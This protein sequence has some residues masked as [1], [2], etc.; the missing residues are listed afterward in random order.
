[1]SLAAL[2][3]IGVGGAALGRLAVP[4]AGLRGHYF[5]NLTRSGAPI[6]V[7]IDR[8]L[9]T[10]TLDNGVAGVWPAYSVE[11]SGFLIVDDAGAYDF[12]TTSDDGS[13]LEVADR[14]VVANGG[15]HG[16]KEVRGSIELARGVHPI[17]VRYE[18]AGGG[19]ALSVRYARA[20]GRLEEIPAAKLLP[21]S[22]SYTQYRLRR[23]V[24]IFSA[25]IAMLLWMAAS[26]ALAR[27]GPSAAPAPR[28][29][30]AIDRP[31][32]ALAII[33]VTAV[34][35]RIVMMLGADPILWG[36]S[37]VFIETFGAI[38]SG[39]L[40]DHDPFRTLLYP[41]FLTAFLS[42]SGEPPMDQI[43]EAAQHLLGV[44]TA[45]CFYL[46]GR[47]VVGP[48][49]ALGG[50]LLVTAHTTQLF[51]EL[52][53][54]SEVLFG[55]V[56]AICLVPMAAFVSKPTVRGAALTGLLCAVLTLTRPVAEWFLV[57]PLG[58]AVL[59]APPW[60]HRLAIGAALAA[61]FLA[62]MLPWSAVNQRQFNFFGIALGR[63]FG[64]FIRV[65]DV[66]RLEPPP[67][68]ALPEIKQM[69]DVGVATQYS[70]A[71]FVR[72]ELGRRHYSTAQ[73]D[74]LM[75]RFAT[76]TIREHPRAF[77]INSLKQWWLQIGG[78]LEDEAICASAQGQYVC[79]KRTQGYAREPFLN[80]PRYEHEPLRPW[81]VAYVRHFQIPMAAVVACAVFGLVTYL[82]GRPRD[83]RRGLLLAGAI[84]YFT[85]LPAFA[86]SPQDRYR[87]PIDGLLFMF[88]VYGVLQLVR[89]LRLHGRTSVTL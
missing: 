76:E 16:P 33:V 57:V 8:S 14:V 72:D 49:A 79:S 85:F 13:E 47:P 43:I 46:A 29:E 77:A 50:A 23:A 78:D 54:L 82:A 44:V 61:T 67:D 83:A 11:W 51:Y 10:D 89:T 21:Q 66:D 27:R 4:A 68:T 31:G 73:S 41:Y 38:R 18:Q 52:S 1:M 56:L 12:A 69:L 7:T 2:A 37:D 74:D 65:F 17:R 32:V 25:A 70:P 45:I 19:F 62:I 84:A 63:G 20:G 28:R 81:V 3:L 53:I 60:R 80:R 71:T 64:L 42:W 75:A 48:R 5:T 35:I 24:P 22:M 88:A 34:A 86:Q 39:R 6:A 15:L 59:G 58:L 36:D 55:C 87:L 26:R 40:L 9:S 30:S